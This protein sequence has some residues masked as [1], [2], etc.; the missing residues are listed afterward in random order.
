MLVG[1]DLPRDESL[2]KPQLFPLD[3]VEVFC[4]R[5]DILTGAARTTE[6]ASHRWPCGDAV[7]GCGRIRGVLSEHAV[8]VGSLHDVGMCRR[9]ARMRA[10][11]H[12]QRSSRVVGDVP[13]SRG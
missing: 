6:L 3:T 12:R 5:A 1:R 13:I 2:E 10:G 4:K 7:R 9:A 11:P 8:Q